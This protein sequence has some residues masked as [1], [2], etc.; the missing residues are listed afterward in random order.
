MRAAIITLLLRA[1]RIALRNHE[2]MHPIPAKRPY[3]VHMSQYDDNV[4]LLL[5][6]IGTGLFLLVPIIS[7]SYKKQKRLQALD[8][9]PIRSGIC[10]YS[11]S[12]FEVFESRDHHCNCDLRCCSC[13][14]C[15]NVKEAR[16]TSR[17]G[18]GMLDH[19]RIRVFHCITSRD[20]NLPIYSLAL[21]SVPSTYRT[22]KQI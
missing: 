6:S 9:Q 21:F 7:L 15:G 12:H 10:C 2:S 5:T 20:Q 8:H 13:R 1:K 17:T 19:S 4:A 18:A 14:L 3:S 16:V 11:A 22:I